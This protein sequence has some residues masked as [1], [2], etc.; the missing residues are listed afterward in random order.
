[1]RHDSGRR[2][3]SYFGHTTLLQHPRARVER[4]AGGAHIVHQHDNG[5]GERARVSRGR[6]RVADVSVTPRCGKAGLR[7]RRA[8]ALQRLKDRETERSCEVGG[9][10]ESALAAPGRMERDRYGMRRGC[11]DVRPALAHQR[12]EGAGQRAATVVFQRVDDG[13]KRAVVRADRAGA[14]DTRSKAPASR[15]E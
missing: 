6:E 15:A 13:A 11:Q 14:I 3:R 5:S 4:R 2:K 10:I 12:A 1:L 8:K 7:G 9:L